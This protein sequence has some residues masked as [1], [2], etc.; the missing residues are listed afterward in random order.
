MGGCYRVRVNLMW[1]CGI[2][3]KNTALGLSL[4]GH[5]SSRLLN[6][7]ISIAKVSTLL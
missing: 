7:E 1:L 5:S 2:I 3:L 6:Y 4:V